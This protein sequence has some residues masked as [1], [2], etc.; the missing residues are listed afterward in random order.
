MNS[1][2]TEKWQKCLIWFSSYF[3]FVAFA[4]IG[5]YTIL[6]S[7]NEEL[8]KTT[9]TSFIICLIFASLSAFLSLFSNFAGMSDKYYGSVAYSFYDIFSRLVSVAEIIVY[10]VIIVMELVKPESEK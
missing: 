8:K 7:E 3:S 4:L 5:G 1:A 9:K 10:A 2:W 6:K